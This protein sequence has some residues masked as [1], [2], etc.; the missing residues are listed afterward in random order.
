M[1]VRKTLD[2]RIGC[3]LLGGLGLEPEQSGE[4]ATQDLLQVPIL[5]GRLLDLE[6][7]HLEVANSGST[8]LKLFRW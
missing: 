5:P 6:N 2:D 8:I 3:R 7:L 4:V 1:R